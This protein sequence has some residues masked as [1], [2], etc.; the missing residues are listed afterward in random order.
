MRK[1][2]LIERKMYLPNYCL[3]C[4]RVD[5]GYNICWKYRRK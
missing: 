5:F 3:W 2:D 1:Y 4:T